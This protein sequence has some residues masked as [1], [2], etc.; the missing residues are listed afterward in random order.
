MIFFLND[1]QYL[2]FFYFLPA[3][4]YVYR[5]GGT[6]SSDQDFSTPFLIRINNFNNNNNNKIL[7]CDCNNE[8]VILIAKFIASNKPIRI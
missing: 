4:M 7:E 5:L 6:F 3:R 2:I 1:C 8:D